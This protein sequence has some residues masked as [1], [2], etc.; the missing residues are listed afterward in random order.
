M[1]P[2]AGR[3]TLVL[4]L[5]FTLS[6]VHEAWARHPHPP[7]QYDDQWLN[8]G[9]DLSNNRWARF[10]KKISTLSAK[11]LTERW[12]VNT[13]GDVTATP[14]IADGI[15][16][17]PDWS[18]A[19]YAVKQRTG[20]VVWKRNLTSL[21]AEFFGTGNRTLLSRS[22]PTIAGD[23][24]LVGI[25]GP[26]AVVALNISTGALQWGK[27][28][29]PHPYGIVTMSGTAYEGYLY[30]GSSSSEESATDICCSFQGAFFK[31]DISSGEIVWKIPML[32]DNGGRIDQYAGNAVWGSSPPIDVTRRLVYI[33]T[34]N[35]YRTPE[36]ITQCE[37]NYRNQTDPPIPDP[38]IEPDNHVESVLAID[39]DTGSI[40]WARHLGGY[41]TWVI[42]CRIP[43]PGSLVNCPTIPG[44][45]YDFGEAPMLLTIPTTGGNNA[46]A[47]G[48]RD[49]VVVGQKS[50]II[51]ALD[52]VSG[53]VIWDTPAGPGGNLGGSIFGMTTDG[54]RVFTN[55]VNV[56]GQN[57]TL[58]PGTTVI[59]GSGWV[60]LNATTG[61]V[62]W[63]TANPSIG[64]STP[65]L[66]HANGVVFGGSAVNTSTGS[67]IVALDAKVGKILKFIA[68]NEPVYGGPSVSGGCAFQPLGIR[69]VRSSSVL[70]L[71]APSAAV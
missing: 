32:P 45:D 44:P 27:L 63:S 3:A 54:L 38:C 64:W 16:Y 9:R 36:E 40:S 26:C 34:G 37:L 5:L 61:Q 43:V 55:I 70:A 7:D 48:F 39:I 13:E 14:S 68:T 42:T 66:T 53:Q 4:T 65:A 10:E 50:G 57:F 1:Q 47:D 31:L 12:I 30:T 6:G 58:A 22:S 17:F 28:L 52:R 25:Y 49:V 19:V 20:E 69:Y 11:H 29:D 60:G 71:C 24:L 41:D 23:R 15:V 46:S 33:A 67:G 51:W 21:A 35:N 59:N 56:E 62:L 2:F 8:H 18:G